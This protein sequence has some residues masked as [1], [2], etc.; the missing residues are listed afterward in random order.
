LKNEED[1]HSA[2]KHPL[3]FVWKVTGRCGSECDECASDIL[4]ARIAQIAHSSSGLVS[5]EPN[6]LAISILIVA[7]YSSIPDVIHEHWRIHVAYGNHI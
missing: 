4:S 5:G 7:G 1:V 2:V 3:L 6:L